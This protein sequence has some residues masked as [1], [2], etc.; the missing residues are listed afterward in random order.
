M[1]NFPK[2]LLDTQEITWVKPGQSVPFMQGAALNRLNHEY[3]TRD[4][5][6]RQGYFIYAPM[7]NNDPLEDM[8]AGRY[9]LIE[10][11]T[12]LDSQELVTALVAFRENGDSIE[13]VALFI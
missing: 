1:K 5:E 10:R 13:G 7:F 8:I 2:Q 4:K 3:P 9:Y 12:M 6:A 11:Q